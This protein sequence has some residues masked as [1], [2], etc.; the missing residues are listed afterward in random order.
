MAMTDYQKSKFR[1]SETFNN[2]NGKTSGSGFVGVIM[3]LVAIVAFIAGI[4][5]WFLH[6]KDALDLLRIVLELAG[7]SIVLLGVRKAAGTVSAK[8]NNR[9]D[10]DKG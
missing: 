2:H 4:V 10:E 9:P 1:L 6:Y 3:G 8:F 7:L 5:G